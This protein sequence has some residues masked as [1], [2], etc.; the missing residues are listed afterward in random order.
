MVLSRPHPNPLP[1]EIVQL[2]AAFCLPR[3]STPK[4]SYSIAQ[5]AAPRSPGLTNLER[6]IALKGRHS[7]NGDRWR[8]RPLRR[9]AESRPFRATVCSRDANPGLHPGLSSDA[10]SVLCIAIDRIVK[11]RT[12]SLARGSKRCCMRL[13]L[14]LQRILESLIVA[15]LVCAAFRL[16]SLALRINDPRYVTILLSASAVTG[17]AVLRPHRTRSC[18]AELSKLRFR[19]RTIFLVTSAICAVCALAPELRDYL[20]L[21]FTI[22][23]SL[24]VMGRT[25]IG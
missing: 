20:V 4:G 22:F 6:T 24:V 9:R 17:T 21:F 23:F 16:C 5:G 18:F 3:F 19:L 8:S 7:L 10:P 12:I 11:S 2:F 1:K 15:G 14:A 13:R 25:L